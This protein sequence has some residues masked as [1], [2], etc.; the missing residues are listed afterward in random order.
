VRSLTQWIRHTKAIK[1]TLLLVKSGKLRDR[2]VRAVAILDSGY[3]VDPDWHTDDPFSA[4][5]LTWIKWTCVV[6]LTEMQ[7]VGAMAL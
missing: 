1:P 6:T 5:R 2:V 3:V 4:S 7:V